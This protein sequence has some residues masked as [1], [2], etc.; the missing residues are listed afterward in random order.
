METGIWGGKEK[1]LE[2]VLYLLLPVFLILYSL[3]INTILMICIYKYSRNKT[4][5]NKTANK[6]DT[7]DC[8]PQPEI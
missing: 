5:F 3:F 6:T 1:L 2:A 7:Q 4:I 8:V